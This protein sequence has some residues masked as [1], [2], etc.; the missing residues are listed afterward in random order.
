MLK[1]VD[2]GADGL[3]MSLRTDSQD[4]WIFQPPLN[5]EMAKKADFAMGIR[6]VDCC[7]IADFIY[8]MC[9]AIARG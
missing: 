1:W 9:M 4:A 3:S 5:V 2:R 7:S 6:I 8:N